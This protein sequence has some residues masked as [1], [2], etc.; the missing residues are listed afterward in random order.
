VLSAGR[1]CGLGRSARCATGE[2]WREEAHAGTAPANLV[3]DFYELLELLGVGDW[4]HDDDGAVTRLGALARCTQ[5]LADFEAMRYRARVDPERPGEIVGGQDR[6]EWHYRWLAI[7]VQ[8]YAMGA[9]EDF[10]GQ[11]VVPLD[12]VELTTVHQAKGLEWPLV[13]I[14]SV[15]GRRF[16]SSNVGKPRAEWHVPT[17]LFDEARYNGS[18]NDERR[19]FYVAL[20]RARDQALVSSFASYPSGRSAG[21]SPLLEE[22]F[23]DSEPIA[24]PEI[25]APPPLPGPGSD[26]ELVEVTLSDLQ[27]YDSCGMSFRL[28]TLLG[29][30]PV[31]A[32]ELGYGRTVHHIMRAVAEHVHST[33]DPPGEEELDRLFD[34]EFFLPL[35][36]K[37]G[38][39]EMKERARGHV[40]RFIDRHADELRGLWAVE[41]PFELR[42]TDALISGRA[43]VILDES[44]GDRPRLTIVDYKTAR[45]SGVEKEHSPF[46]FQ[47]Q[48]YGE[49]G[50]Q[51]GLEI[52]GAYIQDLV[53][54]DRIPVAVDA[55]ALRSTRAK[56]DRL[57]GDL[58]SER[59]EPRPGTIC[60]HCDVSP[61]CRH[62]AQR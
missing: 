18:L 23:G 9:Y 1:R 30:Q 10:D 29:F 59:Y 6:G 8:N 55:G 7:Y 50:N 15:T 39:R 14:P 16:P 52:A 35:A 37:A 12:A 57:I 25:P 62:S 34:E 61:I 28:R 22:V 44:D 36:T 58:K 47:L 56:V 4:D 5:I 20:T 38:H 27:L 31:L 32:R 53:A 24:G 40:R 43:D 11:D 33:G 26:E 42:T 45:L 19:L 41:R 48:V 51:E 21:G 2:A 13:F 3:R 60:R 49:A 17:N 46:E 54:Q